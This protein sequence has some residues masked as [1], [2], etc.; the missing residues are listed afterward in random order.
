MTNNNILNYLKYLKYKI[1]YL[2]LK[3]AGGSNPADDNP[4][5]T[6][7]ETIENVK[8]IIERIKALREKK[9]IIKKMIESRQEDKMNKIREEHMKK[10]NKI[11]QYKN[12]LVEDITYGNGLGLVNNKMME[13]RKIHKKSYGIEWDLGK[14]Q[15]KRLNK[16][17]LRLISLHV[18]DNNIYHDIMTPWGSTQKRLGSQIAQQINALRTELFNLN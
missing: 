8:L 1:K 4:K 12:E 17:L 9:E 11:K 5:K 10:M 16:N 3:G 13:L 7:A 2:Q 14:K 6:K 15:K 18:S